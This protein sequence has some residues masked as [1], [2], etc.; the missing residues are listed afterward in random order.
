MLKQQKIYYKGALT[1]KPQSFKFRAWELETVRTRQ[2]FDSFVDEILVEIRGTDIMR[3]LPVNSSLYEYNWITDKTRFFFDGLKYQRV[4]TPFFSLF[5]NVFSVDWLYSLLFTSFVLFKIKQNWLKYITQKMAALPVTHLNL[6]FIGLN[7]SF[8]SDLPTLINFSILTRSLG[9]GSFLLN[10]QLSTPSM[11]NLNHETNFV[12]SS[13]FDQILKSHSFVFLVGVDIRYELP[14]F[15]LFL[16]QKLKT[17]SFKIFLFNVRLL[18]THKFS[19]IHLGFSLKI[20]VKILEGRHWVNNYLIKTENL[21]SISH[22]FFTGIALDGVFKLNPFSSLIKKFCRKFNLQWFSLYSQPCMLNMGFLNF[23]PNEFFFK[24][25]KFNGVLKSR[26]G[27]VFYETLNNLFKHNA[28]VLN[29]QYVN[30][31]LSPFYDMEDVL[32]CKLSLPM[33]TFFE[34]DFLTMNLLGHTC[35]LKS[36]MSPSFF[37]KSKFEEKTSFDFFWV[38]FCLINL[39]KTTNLSAFLNLIFSSGRFFSSNV[40]IKNKSLSTRLVFSNNESNFIF[41]C[42][43]TNFFQTED[44]SKNSLILN[45]VNNFNIQNGASSNYIK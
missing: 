16:K 35:H 14:K 24:N 15:Y 29:K 26:Q 19:Y 38:L 31:S 32:K 10:N 30:V 22:F 23:R 12:T 25:E 36:F 33:L 41:Q 6:N 13:N 37:D 44:F 45:L 4:T 28:I 1:N 43:V 20:F 7:T 27:I 9:G 42:F 3:I 11:L 18:G 8:F 17:K 40:S 2:L 5:E 34:R 21:Q 39:K